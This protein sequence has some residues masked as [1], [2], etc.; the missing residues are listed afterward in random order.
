[1]TN[2]PYLS[3]IQQSV[4][5]DGITFEEITPDYLYKVKKGEKSFLMNDL[6]MGLNTSSSAKLAASKSGT[7]DVLASHDIK[8]I[9][10]V[11]LLNKHSRFQASDPFQPAE[12]LFFTF[13]E[14]VVVKPDNGAQGKNVFK[15][16]N[17][18]K[19]K[20]T[21]D[22]LFSLHVNV[23]V[24]PFY[25]STFEYRVVTLYGTPKLFLKKERTNSWKHNLINGAASKHMEKE[26]MPLLGEIAERASHALEL[27]YCSVDILDTSHGLLVLEVN[28]QV[29]LE[30]YLRDNPKEKENISEIYREA[31]HKRFETL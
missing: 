21:L 29:M 25:S 28:D 24:S 18:E 16:D 17:L 2:R 20:E 31:I 27:N 1:M 4:A 3:M 14:K 7:Y 8:A 11:F 15:I 26:R 23:A 12:D 19:L 5:H 13:N 10:H 9:E 30:N 22:Y 6:E